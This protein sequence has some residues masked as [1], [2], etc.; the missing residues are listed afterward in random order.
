[1]SERA[2]SFHLDFGNGNDESNNGFASILH[3]FEGAESTMDY[4]VSLTAM[5]HLGCSDVHEEV[6]TVFPAVVAAWMGATEGCAP[7]DANF[8]LESNDNVSA[9]W[10]FNG[11]TFMGDSL[12]ATLDGIT[13][14]DAQH[15]IGLA[16]TSP[17]GCQDSTEI[18]VTVHPV[19]VLSLSTS[20]AASCSGEEWIDLQ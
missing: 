11:S 14:A 17:F 18:M 6:I 1:M 16:V 8:A 12:N 7:L 19:P 4:S 9:T 20:S 5:H 15:T 13:G 10:N 2:D 3:S